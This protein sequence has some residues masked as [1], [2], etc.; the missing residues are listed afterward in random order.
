[1]ATLNGAK[2]LGL[3]DKIGSI[4]VGKDAKVFSIPSTTSISDPYHIILFTN[5][6][7]RQVS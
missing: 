5:E 2:A 1:M 4:E 3:A 7:L 6:R